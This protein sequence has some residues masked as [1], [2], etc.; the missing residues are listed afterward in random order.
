MLGLG[1][2]APAIAD[3]G[4]KWDPIALYGGDIAFEIRRDGEPIGHHWVEFDRI[5]DE[6]QAVSRV[7]LAVDAALYDYYFDYRSRDIWRDGQLLSLETTIDDDGDMSRISAWRSGEDLVVDGPAGI[8]D[9]VPEVFPTNHWNQAAISGQMMLNTL[10]GEV[11]RSNFLPLGEE[12]IE[13]ATGKRAAIKYLLTLDRDIE[14]WYDRAGR[15]VSLR[16]EAFDGS[17]IDYFCLR[18]GAGRPTESASR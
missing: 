5:G 8:F 13:T 18:C 3:P 10:T 2:L 15:W 17:S 6:F 12:T 9:V 14:I 16:F 1:V 4:D 7:D 11:M